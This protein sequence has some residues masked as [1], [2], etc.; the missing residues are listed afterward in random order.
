MVIE[1]KYHRYFNPVNIYQ[2]LCLLALVGAAG[3]SFR[4]IINNF[5]GN[6][7]ILQSAN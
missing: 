4:I 5:K 1:K 6:T 3:N 7:S 2:L